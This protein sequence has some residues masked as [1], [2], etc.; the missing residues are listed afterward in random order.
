M[1]QVCN[2]E[3]SFI[4]KDTSK[5]TLFD[6]AR[7]FPI[8]YYYPTF[9]TNNQSLCHQTSGNRLLDSCD[10]VKKVPNPDR[11]Y[12]SSVDLKVNIYFKLRTSDEKAFPIFI[13]DLLKVVWQTFD[14]VF[15][16]LRY[17]IVF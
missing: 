8:T 4:G 12:M 7:K 15:S 11:T 9:V 16:S 6:F 3:I 5:K 13:P 10:T 1:R 14:A 2:L 17:K